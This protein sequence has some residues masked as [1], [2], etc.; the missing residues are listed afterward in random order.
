[1][2]SEIGNNAKEVMIMEPEEVAALIALAGVILSVGISFGVS[3]LARRYNYHH[4]H[5]EIVSKSRNQWLNEMREYISEML[6]RAN[7]AQNEYKP[8]EYYKARNQVVLRLNLREPLH[9][10]M[11]QQ[12]RALDNC[13]S[14]NYI[15]AIE[16]IIEIS[17]A[18]LKEEWEK[19]KLEAAGKG[20]D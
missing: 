11:L 12:I 1:M 19:V 20:D 16:N 8:Y 15:V 17:Q 9:A 3:M 10:M 4:L 6:A 7:K 18:I 13:T 5:A 2:F 14:N